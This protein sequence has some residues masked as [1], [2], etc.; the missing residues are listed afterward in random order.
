[1]KARSALPLLVAKKSA[2]TQPPQGVP[3]LA[4]MHLNPMTKTSIL[5]ADAETLH[6]LSSPNTFKGKDTSIVAMTPVARTRSSK[7]TLAET[8]VKISAP[9]TTEALLKRAIDV[10]EDYKAQNV[11]VI[12]MAGKSSF[13]DFLIVTN[14]TS[15]RHCASIG[16]ALQEK[17]KKDVLSIEGQ[18]EG[19]WV[20]L[21]A[22][23]VVV[24][25]FTPEKRTLYNLEKLW[26]VTFDDSN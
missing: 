20:C 7:A 3:P 26:S 16:Q 15:T 25:I 12:P 1:M 23:A 6:R 9:S 2:E 17:L 11:V 19:D 21:D 22:G 14:G 18:R 4:I 8:K 5:K 24:H 10:L 13:T